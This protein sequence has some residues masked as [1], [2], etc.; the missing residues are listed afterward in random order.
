M[1]E[2][3]DSRKRDDA[4]V[5]DGFDLAT[6]RRTLIEGLVNA[7]IVIVADVGAKSFAEMLFTEHDHV[8]VALATD[9]SD[10]SLRVYSARGS[11]AR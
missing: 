7:V 1:V 9:R 5:L 11:A 2:P 8:I 4:A 10:D 6:M 3:T